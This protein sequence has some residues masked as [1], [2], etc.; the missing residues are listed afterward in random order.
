M[1]EKLDLIANGKENWI[2]FLEKFYYPFEETVQNGLEE[3]KNVDKAEIPADPTGVFCEKGLELV[4]RGRR[5]NEFLGCSEWP[6]C[7][8][9][10]NLPLPEN[11]KYD[12]HDNPVKCGSRPLPKT[13]K[14]PAEKSGVICLG[15]NELLIRKRKRDQNK[16]LGCRKFPKCKVA[17]PMKPVDDKDIKKWE[18]QK[19]QIMEKCVDK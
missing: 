18:L 4:K 6:D 17:L 8:T 10:L 12:K 11:I 15:E 9:L 14:I 2:E 19:N 7:E 3:A 16:F 1:E 13:E 5:Y